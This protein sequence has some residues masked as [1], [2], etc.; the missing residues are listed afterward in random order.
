MNFK[1]AIIGI[2]IFVLTV[3]FIYYVNEAINPRPKYP[4][5]SS[6]YYDDSYNNSAYRSAQGTYDQELKDHNVRSFVIVLILSILVIIGGVAVKK[7]SPISYGL[8]F[9][10]VASI[11]YVMAVGYEDI[12]KP[13]RAAMTG[14]GLGLMLWVAYR[15]FPPELH[16]TPKASAN[17]VTPPVQL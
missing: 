17:P 11:I 14:I 10:G 7:A 5:Y 16:E 12:D 15:A 1:K 3:L 13:I 9:A 6:S 4:S 8:M 2:A